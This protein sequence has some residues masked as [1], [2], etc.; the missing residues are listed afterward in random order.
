M[1]V[2]DRCLKEIDRALAALDDGRITAR[3]ALEFAYALG[4][5]CAREDFMHRACMGFS[6]ARTH[7]EAMM[8]SFLKTDPPPSR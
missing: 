8:R 5:E 3:A 2:R 7:R 6:E 4:E 1:L